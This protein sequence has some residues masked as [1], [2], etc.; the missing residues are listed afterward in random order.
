MASIT[1]DATAKIAAPPETV[2]AF[3]S[4]PARYPEWSVVTDE[5]THIEDGQ[6]GEGTVYREF[7]G[8]G[9]MTDESEWIIT[10]F[11]PLHRQ[12][13]EGDDG[14]VQT[15][16]TSEIAPLEGGESTR[17]YQRIDLVFPRGFRMLARVLGWLFLRR[18][19]AAALEETVEN[20]KRIVESEGSTTG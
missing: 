9:P 11:D 13:H 17:L 5:M 3:V 8:L 10:S 12:V 18:M 4:D 14:T 6:V 2:W 19:A 1:V 16:L 15:V 7:G 20:A